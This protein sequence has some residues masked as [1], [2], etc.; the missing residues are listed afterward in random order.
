MKKSLI[1]LFLIIGNVLF[2]QNN[3]SKINSTQE[4]IKIQKTILAKDKH[5][6]YNHFLKIQLFEDIKK[7]FISKDYSDELLRKFSDSI[8]S[9]YKA[10][11]E[12]LNSYE[13]EKIL[14]FEEYEK[15]EKERTEDA[16]KSKS[17][18]NE[19]FNISK[20]DS[21]RMA[22][23]MSKMNLSQKTGDVKKDYQ[24]YV[25]QVQ[26]AN[27]ENPFSPINRGLVIQELDNLF[28]NNK[29]FSDETQRLLE[30]NFNP[31]LI[32]SPFPIPVAKKR[33]ELEIYEVIPNDI[34]AFD[35][36][37]GMA[38]QTY[39]NRYKV[40]GNDIIPISTFPVD[41]EWNINNDFLKR[42]SKYV[43]DSAKFYGG[44]DVKITKIKNEYLIETFLYKSDDEPCC[45]TLEIQYK[46]FDF[47]KFVPMKI[48]ENGKN[49]KWK[50]IN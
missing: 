18:Y 42:I 47:K 36:I 40:S 46:T 34:I 35:I 26:K 48:R 20:Q 43:G 12:S 37:Y 39:A 11:D 10:D 24:N 6:F 33:E 28:L 16:K 14:S 45:P 4:L 7:A 38:G 8:L 32:D 13:D 44:N 21:L 5:Q 30:V 49:S 29:T 22:E 17:F 2:A 19:L 25:L 31:S 41:E 9:Q 1:T 15:R 50:T 3:F 27:D 23:V